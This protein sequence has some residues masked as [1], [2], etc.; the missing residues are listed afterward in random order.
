MFS[1]DITLKGHIIDSLTLAK[2]LDETIALGGNFEILEIEV[3][4][5]PYDTSNAVIRIEAKTEL[6]L[7]RIIKR[8]SLHGSQLIHPHNAKLVKAPKKGVFPEGFYSTT[9]LET[10]VRYKNRWLRVTGQEMDVGI[11]FDRK[12][13][14]FYGAPMSDVKKREYY[15]VGHEG[16]R[17]TPLEKKSN[18]PGFQFMSS[19]VSTEKPKARLIAETAHM[20]RENHKNGMR[21][22][23][24]LGPAVVHSG[25]VKGVVELI[26]KGWV[27][28]LF[29]GNALAAHDIEAALYGTSLGVSL[30][31]GDYAEHGHEHHL[32]A[33]NTIRLS[34]SIKAAVKDGFLKSGI[35]H[36]CVT[37]NIPFILAG[38]IRDDGPLPE[39][40]TDSMNVQEILRKNIKKIGVTVVVG[41]VLHGI[42][43]GNLLPAN[44]PIISV[45]I[46]PA[47]IT[48]FSD[49][50]SFQSIGIVMDGASFIHEL[51]TALK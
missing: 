26:K 39:V 6:A 48:K 14:K 44:V 9:N 10:W 24:V 37:C 46:N 33:I 19:E 21:S 18:T 4:K 42:A 8:L 50:G 35:M 32:R 3:G 47:S 36:T 49:R 51:A 30:E 20:L 28:L 1:E 31:G 13:E 40:I 12:K 23:F 15:V 34:G 17:V 22:L 45:D 5:N 27:D 16:V 2:V 43:V 41:T 25:G 38:S 29:A 11:R 7:K